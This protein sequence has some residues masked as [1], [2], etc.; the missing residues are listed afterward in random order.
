MST[1]WL[2]YASVSL[3]RPPLGAS[4]CD[5][6]CYSGTRHIREVLSVGGPPLQ[7]GRCENWSRSTKMAVTAAYCIGM[8]ATGLMGGAQG[9]ATLQIA[10]QVGIIGRGAHASAKNLPQMVRL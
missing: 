9:P 10:Q 8:V 7:A 1:C 2:P 5:N 3:L 6:L 4:A